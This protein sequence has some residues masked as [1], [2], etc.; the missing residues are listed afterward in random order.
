VQEV[1]RVAAGGGH[2]LL[3]LDEIGIAL[4]YGLLDAAEILALVRGKPAGQYLGW[5]A[6]N[7]NHRYRDPVEV[8][9]DNRFLNFRRVVDNTLGTVTFYWDW[10]GTQTEAWIH[11]ELV[12]EPDPS[13]SFTCPAE[14]R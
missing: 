4:H 10:G 2:D 13:A 7:P 9:R 8:D 11:D 12:T 3:I 1:R 14:V 6:N 5:H